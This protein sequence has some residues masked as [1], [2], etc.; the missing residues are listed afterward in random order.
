MGRFPDG[1]TASPLYSMP[2]PTPRAGNIVTNNVNSPVLS[3]IANRSVNEGQL[4]SFTVTATDSDTPSQTLAYSLTGDFPDGASIHP[5]SGNFTWT[6]TELHGV[7]AYPISVKVTDNGDPQL[8]DTKTFVATVNELNVAPTLGPVANQTIDP[9]IT[10]SVQLVAADGDLPPQN[11]NYSVVIGPSGASVDAS[12]LFT[13]TPTLAQAGTSNSVVVSVADSG[14]PVLSAV[15][16][17]SVVVTSGSACLGYKGD[18]TGTNGRVTQADWVLVGR[19]YAQ[20]SE[21]TNECQR[22]LADCGRKVTGG[23]TNWCGDGN[24]GLA[25]WVQAGRY[26]AVLDDWI[27]MADCP[28]PS[29]APAGLRPAADFQPAAALRTM[30]V[31][32]V[33]IEQGQTGCVRILLDAFGDENAMGFSIAYDTNRLTLVS[34]GRGADAAGT[35]INTNIRT[36]GFVGV[37]MTLPSGEVF[38][39]AL[40]QLV[41]ICFTASTGTNAVST[42]IRFPINRLR[43]RWSIR[44]SIPWPPTMRMERWSLPTKMTRFLKRSSGRERMA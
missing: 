14:S 20:L 41:E 24:M 42:P 39:A 17:F 7:G 37:G 11:L 4:L 34:V 27:P 35:I 30:I 38:P 31:T 22:S 26:A 3:F 8:S 21:P 15:R 33:A 40:L 43:E 32:N 12:G 13:W 10:L 44:M 25:D 5:V 28:P 18:V 2:I 19:F 6:P 29:F 36:R 16:N 9:S 1:S 23:V